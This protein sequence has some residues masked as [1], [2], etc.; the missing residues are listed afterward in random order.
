MTEARIVDP[1][2]NVI[3]I[4]HNLAAT[5]HPNRPDPGVPVDGLTFGIAVM[6]K[7]AP[8]GGERHPDGD[9]VLYVVD[10][11]A[12]LI[13]TDDPLPD[14]DLQP[15][16]VV[17]VPKGLWHRVEILEPCHIV[18]LTPGPNGEVRPRDFRRIKP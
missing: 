9:E 3:G 1:D 11:R 5:E 12:R 14:V 17:I 6:T 13:F 7:T 2:I 4:D 10:G 8:H 18:Y 15:G 16:A